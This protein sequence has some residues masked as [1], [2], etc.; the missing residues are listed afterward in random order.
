MCRNGITEVL[1][2]VRHVMKCLI[3]KIV[4]MT[5]DDSENTSGAHKHDIGNMVVYSSRS[6]KTCKYA[7]IFSYIYVNSAMYH[8]T[9]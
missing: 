5:C 9:K 3:I 7:S 2:C 4:S 6:D 1:S 8:R